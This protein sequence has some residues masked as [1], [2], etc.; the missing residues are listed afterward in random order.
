M[1]LL[2][3]SSL[4]SCVLMISCQQKSK[5]AESENVSSA[6]ADSAA[7]DRTYL[8]VNSFIQ[9][10][11][12]KVESFAAGI[13][14]KSTINGKTDSSFIQLTDFKSLSQQFDLPGFDSAYF[15]QH[16]TETSFLEKSTNTVQFLYNARDADNPVRKIIFYV[17]QTDMGDKV[18]MVYLERDT[19]SGDTTT[20]QRLTWKMGHY[21]IIAT[22][23]ETPG[24]Y[25][26]ISKDQVIWESS[27][28]G[29]R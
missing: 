19:V 9:E 4:V 16:Y 10:D 26:K 24:G 27:D 22:N 25:S 21:F 28:F 11:R 13:L 12:N 5:K 23:R 17:K 7:A 6:V 3:V 2:F 15:I 8:P 14:K 18:D 20:S 29:A 1:K